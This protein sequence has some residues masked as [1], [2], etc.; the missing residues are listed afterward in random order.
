MAGLGWLGGEERKK[1]P[2]LPRTLSY[3]PVVV[4]VGVLVVLG[5]SMVQYSIS[6]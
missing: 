2:P 3:L 4:I 5:R 6:E 1:N